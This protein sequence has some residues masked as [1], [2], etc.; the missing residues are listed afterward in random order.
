MVPRVRAAGPSQGMYSETVETGH[1]SSPDQKVIAFAVRYDSPTGG[2]AQVVV[3]F[4]DTPGCAD[5]AATFYQHDAELGLN[6]LDKSTLEV[7]YPEGLRY[8]LPPWGTTIRCVTQTVEV[9]MRPVPNRSG[10]SAETH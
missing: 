10:A 5:S 1:T 6:W 7:L 4:P 9:N 2:I 3:S 8:D